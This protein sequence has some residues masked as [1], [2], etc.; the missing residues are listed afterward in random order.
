LVKGASLPSLRFVRFAKLTALIADI[1][2][3]AG[4]A[5]IVG[6]QTFIFLRVGSW[7]DLPLSL[8]FSAAK[9][10]DTEVYSTASIDKMGESRLADA[11]FEMPIII[12]LFLAAAFL[13]AFYA[14][15]YD[16]EKQLA[17]THIR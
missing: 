11:L 5:L 16:T 6:W 4:A 2:T 15:L 1:W 7:P 13:T 8:V 10:G 17:K 9:N 12:V 3:L 14:W